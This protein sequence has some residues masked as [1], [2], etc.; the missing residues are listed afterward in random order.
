MKLL[1]IGDVVGK[2]GRAAL[3]DRL[4][5]LQEQHA[6]DFTVMNAENVAGGFSIRDSSRI[7]SC[8]LRCIAPQEIRRFGFGER[9]AEAMS[10]GPVPA[11]IPPADPLS[12]QTSGSH[13][14]LQFRAR[15]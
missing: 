5:D 9:P 10:S 14:A 12:P 8:D 7:G 1:L 4:Q 3:L 13:R 2:P 11:E 6:I 15:S